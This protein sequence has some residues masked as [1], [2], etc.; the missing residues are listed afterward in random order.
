M[1]NKVLDT[2]YFKKVTDFGKDVFKSEMNNTGATYN[3]FDFVVNNVIVLILLMVVFG[4]IYWAFSY[5]QNKKKIKSRIERKRK[6]L[7]KCSAIIFICVKRVLNARDKPT[8][9]AHNDSLNLRQ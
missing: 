5:Y 3:I 4:L 8:S 9:I 2:N 1:S 7:Q 6:E